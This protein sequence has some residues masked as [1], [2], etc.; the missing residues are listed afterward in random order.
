MLPFLDK[1]TNASLVPISERV[2]S[3][4]VKVWRLQLFIRKS[5]RKTAGWLAGLD[6][7][8]FLGSPRPSD[9][10][11][12]ELPTTNSRTLASSYPWPRRPSSLKSSRPQSWHVLAPSINQ[13]INQS[14]PPILGGPSSGGSPSLNRS[15]LPDAVRAWRHQ[16]TRNG[17]CASSK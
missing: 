12:Q 8:E 13:S 7:P 5:C 16:R 3:H 10:H 1:P 17:W 14:P 6:D 4:S 9:W 11:Q 2:G 15:C